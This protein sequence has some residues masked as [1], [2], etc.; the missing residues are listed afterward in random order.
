MRALFMS[1]P[2]AASVGKSHHTQCPRFWPA[3]NSA[4]AA[5]LSYDERL[6]SVAMRSSSDF[7]LWRW[8]R[9]AAARG[10]A[11]QKK[12]LRPSV[13]AARARLSTGVNR[14]GKG[15]EV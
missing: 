8:P 7:W 13:V 9:M 10:C 5:S 2:R 4:S 15:D 14:S 12:A 11:S 1:P 3:R 6:A